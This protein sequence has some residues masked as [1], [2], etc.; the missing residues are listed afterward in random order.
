MDYA[1]FARKALDDQ[2]L[3]RAECRDVLSSPDD[4]NLLFIGIDERSTSDAAE[5][6]GR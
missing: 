6:S 1:V 5:G 2:I 3:T 4:S